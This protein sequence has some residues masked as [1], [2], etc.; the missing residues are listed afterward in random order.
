MTVSNGIRSPNIRYCLRYFVRDPSI[1][2]R[3]FGAISFPES[4]CGPAV[5]KGN[6]DSGNEIGG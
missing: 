5:S 2:E 3:V 4:A 6:A 1:D